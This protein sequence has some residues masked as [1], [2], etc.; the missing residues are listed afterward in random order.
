MFFQMFNVVYLS[1]APT[2][3]LHIKITFSII[4]TLDDISVR[5]EVCLRKSLR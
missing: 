2:G 3:M 4:T 1:V 5:S